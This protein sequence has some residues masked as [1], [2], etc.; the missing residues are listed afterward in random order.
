MEL[1]L[2]TVCVIGL[3][4][5][6]AVLRNARSALRGT[7]LTMAWRWSVAAWMAWTIA[8]FLSL[9]GDRVPAGLLDQA[10]YI[11]ALLA[12]CPPIA[13]LGAKQPMARVWSVFILFPLVLV[14]GWPAASAWGAG[15]PAAGWVVEEPVTAG[16]A[17]VLLMG[18]GNYIGTRY[19]LCAVLYGFSLLLV[20]GQL[21]PPFAARLPA[22]ELLRMASIL[23]LVA[24]AWYGAWR[25]YRVSPAATPFDRLWQ[26]FRNQFGI[27][28]GRRIQERFNETAARS[29]W[30]MRLESGGLAPARRE[31]GPVGQTFPVR[32]ALPAEGT[33]DVPEVR[34]R[35][36][37]A[38]R[39]LL[40][41][42]VEPAW[43]ERQLGTAHEEG[44]A[45]PGD[46][47]SEGT[48]GV[49]PTPSPG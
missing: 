4:S 20:V 1:L 35:I 16:F 33:R 39:W 25:S 7:T 31:D 18:L 36:E 13:V 44:K 49:A 11:A 26:E 40:R 37:A 48:T 15:F 42:F 45:V 12:V 2:Q 27:V 46:R 10:W 23:S 19:R 41:R 30:P 21:C 29:G 38:L 9:S 28:W 6:A 43:I 32:S 22:A 3:L 8:G 34:A 47:P 17:F 14:L 24:A 5:V